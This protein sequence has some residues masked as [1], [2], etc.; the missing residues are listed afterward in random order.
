MAP[1]GFSNSVC[2][3][4][5]TIPRERSR[6]MKPAAERSVSSSGT[7]GIRVTAACASNGGFTGSPSRRETLAKLMRLLPHS[8]PSTMSGISQTADL[9]PLR[10]ITAR[11]SIDTGALARGRRIERSDV[12]AQL[13]GS[14][15][16]VIPPTTSIKN[17]TAAIDAAPRDAIVRG[18]ERWPTN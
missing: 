15:S 4:A 10:R 5:A 1:A 2:S 6:E 11:V 13:L 16:I 7:D 3:S 8:T 18:E 17:A 12:N 9:P 14:V